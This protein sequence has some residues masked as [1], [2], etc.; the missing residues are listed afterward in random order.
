M[1]TGRDPVPIEA[2]K[3]LSGYNGI[4]EQLVAF[5]PAT[6]WHMSNTYFDGIKYTGPLNQ[7]PINPLTVEDWMKDH[8]ERIKQ[9]KAA[10]EAEK[11]A[12]L[13]E[14]EKRATIV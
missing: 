7:N 4:D 12:F 3:V 8:E 14:M 6:P 1:S 13:A 9:M 2:Y 10:Q 5:V 11:A